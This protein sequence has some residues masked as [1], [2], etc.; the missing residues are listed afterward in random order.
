[1]AP[2]PAKAARSIN[3]VMWS[4]LMKATW[5]TFLANLGVNVMLPPCPVLHA[6]ASASAP[7]TLVHRSI[8]RIPLQQWRMQQ[9][10]A[11]KKKG[12]MNRPAADIK[13]SVQ[14]AMLFMERAACG[15]CLP[16]GVR[17]AHVHRWHLRLSLRQRPHAR[18]IYYTVGNCQLFHLP[19][20]TL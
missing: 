14:L 13:L 11:G 15:I 19:V 2:V 18:T 5:F 1:M 4:S 9:W 16:Q 3:P 7:S 6:R 10:P 8:S 12:E 20:S 17:D